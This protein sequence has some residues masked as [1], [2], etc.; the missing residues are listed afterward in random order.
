MPALV[1]AGRSRPRGLAGV[2]EDEAGRVVDEE[3]V[4]RQRVR[5]PAAAEV[6]PHALR[7]LLGTDTP[8]REALDLHASAVAAVAAAQVPDDADRYRQDSD[9]VV[10]RVE[11]DPERRLDPSAPPRQQAVEGGVQRDERPEGREGPPRPAAEHGDRGDDGRER[12]QTMP[13][14]EV[15]RRRPAPV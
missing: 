15:E 5:A 10:Q 2:E 4:D 9:E 13:P 11:P 6:A 8:R 7:G 14:A 3:D 1:I 12:A